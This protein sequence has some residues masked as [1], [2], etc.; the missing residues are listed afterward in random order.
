MRR[1]QD[2]PNKYHLRGKLLGLIAERLAVLGAVDAFQTDFDF[3]A[4]VENTE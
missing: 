2:F 4:V 3:L 1:N